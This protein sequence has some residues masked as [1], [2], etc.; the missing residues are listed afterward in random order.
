[1]IVLRDKETRLVLRPL[2]SHGLYLCLSSLLS[3]LAHF[4]FILCFLGCL[5]LFLWIRS[6]LSRGQS[7]PSIT[8][9]LTYVC[10][11]SF[12]WGCG[13]RW[14]IHELFITS[15]LFL[16]LLVRRLQSLH[17]PTSV[18]HSRSCLTHCWALT[19]NLIPTT[20]ACFMFS[21][22]AHEQTVCVCFC[23]CVGKGNLCLSLCDEM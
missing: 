2:V 16:R 9:N 19:C 1:M 13:L 8:S 12:L 5:Q 11:S 22:W 17:C 7:N 14:I 4:S 18:Q 20:S 3:P 23:V 21:L 15:L 10:W 6:D